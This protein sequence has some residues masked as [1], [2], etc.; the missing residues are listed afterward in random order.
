M[1]KSLINKLN[2]MVHIGGNEIEFYGTMR[3]GD[4]SV[5]K[6]SKNKIHIEKDRIIE[7]INTRE[8]IIYFDDFVEIHGI[9][10][11]VEIYELALL[12]VP[13]YVD[14]EEELIDKIDVIVDGF[15]QSHDGFKLIQKLIKEYK[16]D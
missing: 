13:S 15:Q 14:D 10:K 9:T 2:K 7:G 11:F 5:I 4:G 6:I 16:N 3:V 12:K 8:S 1:K